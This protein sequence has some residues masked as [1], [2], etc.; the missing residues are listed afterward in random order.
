MIMFKIKEKLLMKAA[1][2]EFSINKYTRRAFV[3][4]RLPRK[5]AIMKDF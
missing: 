4:P 2:L 5:R 3:L 1:A